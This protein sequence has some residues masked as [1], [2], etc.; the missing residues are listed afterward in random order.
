MKRLKILLLLLD[1]MLVHRRKPPRFPCQFAGTHLY[2]WVERGTTRVKCLAQEHNTMIR[3]R[4]EPRPLDLESSTLTTWPPCLPPRRGKT[5]LDTMNIYTKQLVTKL[6]G[7]I[8]VNILIG[9]LV[10]LVII[11]AYAP[12]NNNKTLRVKSMASLKKEKNL[13]KLHFVQS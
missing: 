10:S 1:G 9:V 13:L 8:K 7:E 5:I 11:I 2:S 6:L 3:P 12:Y 4:L